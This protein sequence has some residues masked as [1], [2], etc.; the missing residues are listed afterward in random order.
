MKLKV[1]QKVDALYLTLT[2]ASA[3]RSEEV[4]PGI[5]VDYN[6]QDCVHLRGDSAGQLSARASRRGARRGCRLRR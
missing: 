1:D 4:S 6:D 2:E 3:S 5:V